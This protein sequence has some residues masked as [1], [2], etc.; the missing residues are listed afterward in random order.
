MKLG[1][2]P[3]FTLLLPYVLVLAKELILTG[4]V[5]VGIHMLLADSVCMS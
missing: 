4:Q 2:T 3:Y 1:V 5:Y